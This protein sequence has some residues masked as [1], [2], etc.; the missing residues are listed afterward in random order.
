[1][2]LCAVAECDRVA[3]TRGMC[4]P[5]YVKAWRRGELADAP[6]SRA[7]FSAD[8]IAP[9]DCYQCGKPAGE[10]RHKRKRCKACSYDSPSVTCSEADCGRAARA[11]GLCD[12]HY[13][14]DAR[15]DGRIQDAP[16]DERRRANY[17]RRRARKMGAAVGK[18]FTNAAV[19]ERDSWECG[20][21]GEPVDSGLEYPD[22]LSASLDHVVPL[23]LGGAHSLENVQLAHL[24]CNVRKGARVEVSELS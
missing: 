19:Y 13:K 24:S 6:R 5:H 12:M 18:S 17:E 11:R 21:C 16:W 14:R 2:G 9:R 10:S 4:R 3:Q 20:L 22:P 23:S 1:M 15:K 8:N 7:E